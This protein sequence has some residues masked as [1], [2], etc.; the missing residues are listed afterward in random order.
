MLNVTEFNSSH[1]VLHIFSSL[2]NTDR[3]V[4]GELCNF[5]EFWNFASLWHNLRHRQ[6]QFSKLCP[7]GLH[8][9]SQ[10]SKDLSNLVLSRGL[11]GS[12]CREERG[13]KLP[14]KVWDVK[15]LCLF[16]LSLLVSVARSKSGD[17]LMSGKDV[18]PNSVSIINSISI[19]QFFWVPNQI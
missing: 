11:D 16:V 5:T 8:F 17:L 19:Q 9:F 4:R 15:W 3:K 7:L 12:Q 6:V 13:R 10:F 18:R 14:M 1:L 2:V